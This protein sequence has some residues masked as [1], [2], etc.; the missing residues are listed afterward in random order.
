MSYVHS[1]GWS[2]SLLKVDGRLA[3]LGTLAIVVYAVALASPVKLA[4]LEFFLVLFLAVIGAPPGWAAKRVALVIPFGGVLA[5]FQLFIRPGT[6]IAQ[7]G[8]LSISQEGLDVG[9]LLFMRVLVAI[10][11]VVV[12]N[13][14][15]GLPSLL[16]GA[17]RLRVPGVMV[18]MLGLT[19]RYIPLFLSSI[20]KVT[21]AQKLR[22]F[23]TWDRRLPY[24]WRLRQLGWVAGSI[25]LSS[26]RG[27][28]RT[29]MA[30][31]CRGL[32]QDVQKLPALATVG[33][34]GIAYIAT[35]C[36]VLA[37]VHLAGNTMM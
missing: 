26:L 24:R 21:L 11:S 29:Y 9:V 2:E 1:H 8:P 18:D 17:R 3:I 12:L 27:G 34:A 35:V 37:A 28:Q 33:R 25:F 10:T 14:I 13:S 5:F 22:A 36:C 31:L 16:E 15:T 6:I 20:H 7:I 19:V 30:M 32:R 23:S 4:L